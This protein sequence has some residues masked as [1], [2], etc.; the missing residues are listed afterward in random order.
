M[1]EDDQKFIEI[2]KVNIELLQSY[3]LN[4]TSKI[5]DIGSGYGRLACFKYANS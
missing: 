3:G 5:L 4:E 1:N 2:G